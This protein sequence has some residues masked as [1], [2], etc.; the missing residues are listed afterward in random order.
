MAAI[1]GAKQPVRQKVCLTENELRTVLAKLPE[2]GRPNALALKI[3][4]ATCTRKGELTAAKWEH[5]DFEQNLWTIP[6]ENSKNAKAFVIPLVPAVVGWFL[7]LR[8]LACGSP[9][10]LPGR[11]CRDPLSPMALN[12]ALNRLGTGVR[13]FTIHDL[14]RTARSHLGALGV[15][16]IIAEK[17]L[18]H[19]LG[20]LIDVYDRGDYLPER[21][22]ALELW[23]AFLVSCDQ[24]KPWNVMPLRSE[25]A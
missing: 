14:R 23:A 18:N 9:W 1:I 10:V 13:H 12:A 20:G 6:S 4:L 16:V 17:C 2:I 21:R 22:R 11:R 25:A 5:L 15:D 7:E 24:G 19:T 3:I 8:A